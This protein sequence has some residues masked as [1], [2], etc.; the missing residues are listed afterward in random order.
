MLQHSRSIKKE[1]FI[2]IICSTEKY[3]IIAK[4][5]FSKKSGI[6]KF[7]KKLATLRYAEVFSAHLGIENKVVY[8][9]KLS[10]YTSGVRI[11]DF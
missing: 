9:A 2:I 8:D 3:N 5:C 10:V 1:T 4:L 6:K 7:K 11:P